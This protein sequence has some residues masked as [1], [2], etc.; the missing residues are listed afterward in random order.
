MPTIKNIDIFKYDVK[1]TSPFLIS[2]GKHLKSYGIILAVKTDEG[3]IGYG[4]VHPSP[5]LTN[6]TQPEALDFLLE[7]KTKLIGL[8]SSDVEGMH[9]ILIKQGLTTQ[10]PKVALDFACYDIKG[11]VKGSPIYKLLGCSK[12]RKVPTTVT[13]S[14]RSPGEMAKIAQEY[15]QKYRVNGIKRIKLKLQGDPKVDKKRVEFVANVFSGELTLD[16]NQGFRDPKIAARF[17]NELYGEFG[18]RILYVEEPCPKGDIEK[19]R[20]VTDYST[21]PVFADES[22][23]QIED[24]QKIVEQQAAK[25]INIKLHKAGGIYWGIKIAKIAKKAGVDVM[26]GG[27]GTGIATAAGAN[28]VAGTPN[29]N[30]ADLDTDLLL[31]ANI[32]KKGTGASFEDGARIPSEKPGLGVELQGCI[33]SVFNGDMSIQKVSN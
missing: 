6:D 8:D 9:E 1:F 31:R 22:A 18:E 5:T 30:H 25:G 23:G 28:F 15:A 14:I 12:P 20:Y 19:L 32:V 26:V 4:E 7:N 13:I 17:F 3:F 29:V 27:G 16:V 24:V 10:S 2:Y 33:A 21:I 11:K